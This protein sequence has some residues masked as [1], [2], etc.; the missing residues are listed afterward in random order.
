MVWP[1]QHLSRIRSPPL[2]A[3]QSRGG[4][5]VPAGELVEPRVPVKAATR[6]EGARIEP[7]YDPLAD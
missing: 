2:E 1:A 4:V 6:G 3:R 7:D 5:R